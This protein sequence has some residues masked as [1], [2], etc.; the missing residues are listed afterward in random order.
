MISELSFVGIDVSKARLDVHI[1]PAGHVL[2]LANISEHF[3]DLIARLR[4][5]GASVVGLE[6]S[7][8]YERP[9]ADALHAAG[10]D[11]RI[12][13]PSR[14]RGFARS[15]GQLAKTDAIDAAV[16]A[17]YLAT[18]HQALAPYRRDPALGSLGALLGHRRRLV[19]ERS[20]LLSQC[21]TETEPL[22]LSL[23]EE[24]LAAI[25]RAIVRIKDAVHAL[26]ADNPAV[27]GVGPV[28][29]T[30]LLAD[31]PE[32]G[33]VS[34]KTV[35]ALLG[36]APHAR[37]SGKANRPGR[38]SGGRKHLRDIAYMAVLSAIKA[39]DPVLGGFYKRLRQNGKPFKLAMV[40]TIRKLITIL[41]AIARTD[42]AFAP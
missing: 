28:L 41:N 8:G 5:L 1:H 22:V 23:I 30:T 3:S 36:V 29:A 11:V 38:C 35:A 7:G 24:R 15:I 32:L 39:A 25:E 14:V 19:A 31:L 6:A 37:Q 21:D 17:R 2:V 16:I 27:S 10:I 13:Q 20:G 34:G 40:A 4:V 26:V 33:Q 9:L 42:P 12:L 18:A